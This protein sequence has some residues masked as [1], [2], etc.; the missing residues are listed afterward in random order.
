MFSVFLNSNFQV[1]LLKFVENFAS[2]EFENQY[3]RNFIEILLPYSI[4][5]KQ[6][7]NYNLSFPYEK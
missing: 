7:V 1:I 2:Y 4:H 5:G 3:Y 6:S